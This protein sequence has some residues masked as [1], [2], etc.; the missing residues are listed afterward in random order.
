MKAAANRTCDGDWFMV[1]GSNKFFSVFW[2]EEAL[3]YIEAGEIYSGQNASIFNPLTAGV[4]YIW[5]SFFIS[6]T[7]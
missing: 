1:N 7:F 5:V 6:T 4:A 2:P 3:S